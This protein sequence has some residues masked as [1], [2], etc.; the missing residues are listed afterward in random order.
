MPASVA[1]VATMPN[2]P[3]QG[4]VYENDDSDRHAYEQLAF[5]ATEYLATQTGAFDADLTD[6]DGNIQYFKDVL[7]SVAIAV[8]TNTVL[9]T[10]HITVAGSGKKIVFKAPTNAVT[11]KV[12]AAVVPYKMMLNY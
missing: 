3:Q 7:F 10:D 4:R 9:R 5:I 1:I 6:K 12:F 11:Y 8:N 2:K